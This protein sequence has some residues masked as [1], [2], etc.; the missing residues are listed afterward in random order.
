MALDPVFEQNISTW[1]ESQFPQ[2]YRDTGPVFVDFVRTYYE[3]MESARRLPLYD[4]RHAFDFRDIDLTITEFLKFFRDKYLPGIPLETTTNTRLLV[5]HSLDVYRSRATPQGL[6]LLFRLVFGKGA[7]VYFP[8]ED[9]FKLSDGKYLRPT[10]LEVSVREDNARFAG[11]DVLGVTSR[12]IG[13]V[14][15]YV[16]RTSSAG[17]IIDVLY[18]SAVVGDFQTGEIINAKNTPFEALTCPKVVGSL[19]ELEVTE[20]GRSFDIGDEVELI[21]TIG[22]Y[23]GQAVVSEIQALGG[24]ANFT[25]ESGGYG[26]TVNALPLVSEKVVVMAGVQAGLLREQ[27]GPVWDL[28]FE[29]DYFWFFDQ[30]RQPLA[31]LNYR[32]LANGTFANNDSLTAWFNNAPVGTGTVLGTPTV[33]NS[34]AGVLLVSILTGNLSANIIGSAGNAAL[35]NLAVSNGFF[36]VAATGNVI[37]QSNTSTIVIS[38]TVGSFVPGEEL[39]QNDDVIASIKTWGLTTG[40]TSR[41]QLI[42][43]IVVVSG[44]TVTGATSG[45]T[46]NVANVRIEVGVI[47]VNNSF[48]VDPRAPG[49]SVGAQ[50]VFLVDSLGVGSGA[51]FRVG[52][53]IYPETVSLNDDVAWDYTDV[54]INATGFGFPANPSANVGNLINIALTY[55]S[56][57]IGRVASLAGQNPGQDYSND[58]KCRVFEPLTYPYAQLDWKLDVSNSQ[59]FSVGELVTQNSTGARGLVFSANAT[60]MYLERLS[61]FKEFVPTINATTLIEGV[62]S[63]STANVDVVS[64]FTPELVPDAIEGEYVGADAQVRANVQFAM[65]NL[66]TNGSAVSLR[67]SASGY[68]WSDGEVVSFQHGNSSGV[69]L[70]RLGR[71]GTAPGYYKI[72]GGFLSDQK[73][74]FDGYYWQDFS[75]EVRAA[76]TFDKYS[77]MLRRVLHVAGTKAFGALWWQTVD[78]VPSSVTSATVTTT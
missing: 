55:T 30:V 3:W 51:D 12:A 11:L 68:G 23:G 61:L 65:T 25:L 31:Y 28:E 69:A 49:Y 70:A 38:D 40:S 75:Y 58:P 18:V 43:S 72:K 37:A 17:K 2:V 26:Y 77:E 34:T 54:M 15:R 53:L 8:G 66:T 20:G 13:F 33:T 24:G 63:G 52:S 9:L 42:N 19:F 47:D 67:V 4:S 64:T 41:A 45:A 21:G 35:A 44:Q 76:L 46:G 27:T 5:K 74:L 6:D 60:V 71:Q 22:G 56:Y 16:R 32:N 36:D 14:E 62:S 7:D 50:T 73:K 39:L 29:D 48:L 78:P 10:Y 59:S 1:V 57:E